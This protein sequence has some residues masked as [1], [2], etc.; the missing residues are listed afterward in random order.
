MEKKGRRTSHVKLVGNV[1]MKSGGKDEENI[2]CSSYVDIRHTYTNLI[3]REVSIDVCYEYKGGKNIINMPR[4]ILTKNAILNELPKFGIDISDDNVRDVLNWLLLRESQAPMS[5]THSAVGWV[6]VNNERVYLLDE[7][8]SASGVKSEYKGELSIAPH[9][10]LEDHIHLLE[11]EVM[12]N[13]HLEL[14]YC[15]GLSAII[16]SLLKEL[17]ST[18]VG[19]YHFWGP[20][21]SGKSSALYLACSSYGLPRKSKDGIVLS[22]TATD[23][24]ISAYM[25]SKNGFLFAL[26][27]SSSRYGKDFSNQIYFLVDGMSKNR[28][29]IEGNL[30]PRD[31]WSG[32]IISTGENSLLNDANQN[33]GIKVRILELGFQKWT[34]SAENSRNLQ[35]GLIKTYG[36]TARLLARKI[37]EIG[38]VEILSRYEDSR[39]IVINRF[40]EVDEFSD[41]TA[42]K[43]ACVYLTAAL[44]KETL[45]LDVNAEELLRILID[46]ERESMPD[47]DLATKAYEHILNEVNQNQGKFYRWEL[48]E[49]YRNENTMYDIDIAPREILGRINY[50]RGVPEDLFITTNALNQFL[51]S[52]KFT[53]RDVVVKALKKKNMLILEGKAG[54]NQLARKLYREAVT[55]VRVYAFKLDEKHES[56]LVSPAIVKRNISSETKRKKASSEGFLDLDFDSEKEDVQDVKIVEKVKKTLPK[57]KIS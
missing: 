55:E 34:T 7:A 1:L 47:R 17:L 26:D 46:S 42:D 24:G 44:V 41:R 23:N 49:R 50:R 56:M 13:Y 11:T 20:S 4:S 5:Y 22:W 6:N 21:S 18:S 43:I 14:A 12:G 28:S 53:S 57:R 52:G 40:G 51:K 32:V 38:D 54:K 10:S 36:H 3:T 25:K 9:G 29:T 35:E 37:I 16:S 19:F 31:A 8:I 15:I 27:E 45:G 39:K 30:R 33:P 48:D 2:Y